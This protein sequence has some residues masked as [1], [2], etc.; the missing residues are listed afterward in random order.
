MGLQNH[1]V[2]LSSPVSTSYLCTRAANSLDIDPHAKSVH[3]L[4]VDADV[5]SPFG[6]GL[7]LG[8]SGS[9]KTTLARQIYGDD[10]LVEVLDLA[11]PVIEQF[12]PE[13]DYDRCSS[14][15]LAIGLSSVPCWI[16]P[17]HTLSNGQRA[18][19]D[20]ALRLARS[21]SAVVV[22]DEWTSVVDR[23]VAKA[24]SHCVQRHV[25][26]F[27]GSIVLLSC[28]YDVVEW[29]D[30]DW[31]I[32][33]NSSSFDDRRS[34]LPGQRFERA[35]RLTFE[36]AECDTTS[37]PYFAKY[38]YLTDKLP[39]GL[40]ISFGV[41]CNDRQIG[42]VNFAN[43]VPRRRFGRFKLHS[44]RLVIHPDYVGF[45]LGARVLNAC[46]PIVAAR[47]FDVW[48]KFSSVPVFKAL[49]RHPDLWA[50]RSVQRDTPAP[51]A[52]MDRKTGF[53]RHVKTW[54]F[55]YVG[56]VE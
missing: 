30:P 27:G 54:S 36:I 7:I 20:A 47:G 43:Y 52:M 19:A 46:A 49:S 29:L 8:A 3:E 13:W 9:G 6:I 55:E 1:R 45:G 26:K 21:G 38:H 17:A 23:V 42:F 12:P 34:L 2:R 5:D 51:G 15:L 37:W 53:R 16:R 4:S 28:H 50:L 41:Y 10:A 24:M 44:N 33:C 32:D 39:G 40:S 25:R 35:D 18:R 14:A 48:S 56:P 11:R 22:I 31:I